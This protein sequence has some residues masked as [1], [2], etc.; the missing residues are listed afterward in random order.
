[1]RAR[2]A[3]SEP[4]ASALLHGETFTGAAI[5]SEPGVGDVSPRA[6]LSWLP[7]GRLVPGVGLAGDAEMSRRARRAGAG[8]YRP[9]PVDARS[10]AIALACA[11]G[12]AVSHGLYVTDIPRQMRSRDPP[13]ACK[14]A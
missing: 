1:M 8:A 14:G 11:G 4:E 6:R 2:L 12:R 7:S 9:R 5:A 13:G 10:Q 3:R